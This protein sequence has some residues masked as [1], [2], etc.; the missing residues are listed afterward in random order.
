MIC[1]VLANFLKGE[2]IETE[3]YNNLILHKLQ[4]EVY[5]L[6]C[7]SEFTNLSGYQV[8]FIFFHFYS[9]YILL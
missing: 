5:Y 2:G 8:P 9:I 1:N 3:F 4:K 7:I 6:V